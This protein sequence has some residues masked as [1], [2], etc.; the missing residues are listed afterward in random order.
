M[1]AAANP[2]YDAVVFQNLLRCMLVKDKIFLP[3][4]TKN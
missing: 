3:D 1:D 2:I 4:I